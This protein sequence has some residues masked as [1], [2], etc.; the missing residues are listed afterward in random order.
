[1]PGSQEQN[2]CEDPCASEDT[3]SRRTPQHDVDSLGPQCGITVDDQKTGQGAA[4]LEAPEDQSNCTQA[5][6]AT[7]AY[8]AERSACLQGAVVEGCPDQATSAAELC[9][10]PQAEAGLQSAAKM[11]AEKHENVADLQT[12]LFVPECLLP[13]DVDKEDSPPLGTTRR[14]FEMAQ[15]FRYECGSPTFHFWLGK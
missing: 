3:E 13:G 2:A 9:S 1:M 5:V 10:R 8:A 4:V 14:S 6:K 7:A 11:S 15:S 12:D